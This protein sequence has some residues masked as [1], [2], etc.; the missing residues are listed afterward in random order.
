MKAFEELEAELT[1]GGY[2]DNGEE[3]AGAEDYGDYE[4]ERLEANADY[5]VDDLTQDEYNSTL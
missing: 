3:L 5:D 1:S 4:T 2:L